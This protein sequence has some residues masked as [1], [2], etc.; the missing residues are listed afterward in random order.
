M[1][2]RIYFVICE[3]LAA[4]KIGFTSGNP[5]ERIKALQTGCPSPLK[6]V[7]HV[8][9]SQD[10]ERR[11]HRAFNPLHI[12]GEWFRF[13]GKLIDFVHYLRRESGSASRQ[14]FE[15]A[16]HDV[17]MQGIWTWDDC[18]P[19]GEDY[20]E[21]GDWEPFRYLLWQKYGPWEVA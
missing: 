6:G 10:E 9:G 14:R 17:L 13:E 21:T 15:D 16:L 8:P 2:G 19:E 5:R 3:P 4:I 11:L 18:A 20:Y 7:V 1:S 12:H